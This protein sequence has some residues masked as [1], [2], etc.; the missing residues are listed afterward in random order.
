M[1]KFYHG[2]VW[3]VVLNLAYN[4][5]H[6]CTNFIMGG[7]DWLLN[8]PCNYRHLCTNFNMGGFD[9]LLIMPYN[10]H[11]CTNFTMSGFNWLLNLPYNYRHLCTNFYHE[12]VWLVVL[13]LAYNYTPVYKFY[14][15]WVWLVVKLAI[16]DT[17][18]KFLPWMGFISCVKLVI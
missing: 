17:V 4:Y 14:H 8:L 16:W 12:W 13:N 1:Y 15:G 9:W 6:L 10:R 3:L 5:R 2:W 11:M 18:Y 7:F